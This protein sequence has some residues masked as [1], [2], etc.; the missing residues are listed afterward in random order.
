MFIIKIEALIN[1]LVSGLPKTRVFGD[2][3]VI[4]LALYLFKS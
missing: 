4:T 3:K 2:Y 1:N